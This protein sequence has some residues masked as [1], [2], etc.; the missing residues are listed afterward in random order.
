MGRISKAAAVAIASG[1]QTP[2]LRITLE[3]WKTRQKMA[4][5]T[6]RMTM[7]KAQ[8]IQ[9]KGGVGPSETGSHGWTWM[10]IWN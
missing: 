2:I 6:G 5:T 3:I 9:T 4:M 10:G 1:V 8:W 7:R